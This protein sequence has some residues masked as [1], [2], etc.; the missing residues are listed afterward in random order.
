MYKA[1]FII[2]GNGYW[3]FGTQVN[4]KKPITH[5][6]CKKQAYKTFSPNMRTYTQHNYQLTGTGSEVRKCPCCVTRCLC[7]GIQDNG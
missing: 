7:G 6:W 4:L 2:V 1:Q 5:M 3:K